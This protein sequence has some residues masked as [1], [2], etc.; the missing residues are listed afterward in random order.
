MIALSLFLPFAF[1]GS[2]R[3]PAAYADGADIN[4]LFDISHDTPEGFAYGSGDGLSPESPFLIS[5]PRHIENIKPYLENNPSKPIPYFAF[6]EDICPIEFG[7][8]FG[9]AVM[10]LPCK[11]FDGTRRLIL[12][13]QSVGQYDKNKPIELKTPADFTEERLERSA[14]FYD[15]GVFGYETNFDYQV[16]IVPLYE[17]RKA[18]LTVWVENRGRINP[19][20]SVSDIEGL[21][22]GDDRSVIG[23]L[24]PFDNKL[25]SF[26]YGLKNVG[27]GTYENVKVDGG[28]SA[29][30]YNIIYNLTVTGL[31]INEIILIA[32][33]GIVFLALTAWAVVWFGVKKKTLR[34]I[35]V[36]EK[37]IIKTVV[38]EIPMQNGHHPLPYEEFTPREKEVAE[39]LLIGK[40]RREIAEELFISEHTVKSHSENIF[41]KCFVKTQKALIGK[42][43]LGADN[44]HPVTS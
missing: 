22:L 14:K 34:Q 15:V 16:Y 33:G 31:Y 20:Y 36:R 42:Y 30:N 2:R 38:K 44:D 23:G 26:D 24:H 28:L 19:V 8:Q 13:F 6:A 9:N 17:V 1:F 41:S 39:L 18:E 4:R 43:V 32:I 7:K 21:R 3:L 29:D 27:R 12:E 35:F 40:S 5:A 10:L 25:P 37:T 11:I